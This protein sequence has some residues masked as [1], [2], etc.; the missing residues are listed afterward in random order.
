MEYLIG[1]AST[2]GKVVNQHFGRT[3][4]FIIV[5]VEG[6]REY[7]FI[8]KR[9]VIAVCNGGEHDEKALDTLIEELSDCKYVLCSQ[10]GRNAEISLRSK[11][12]L[13]LEISHF[14]DY[15]INKVMKYDEKFNRNIYALKS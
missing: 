5:R 10:I 15:A 14:I 9:K 13:S 1:I 4:E 12:I 8:G 11:G 7:H 6:N 2:D 3:K